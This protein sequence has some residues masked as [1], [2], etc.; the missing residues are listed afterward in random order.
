VNVPADI[1]RAHEQVV[2]G[3]RWFGW[4]HH[5]TIKRE[6][7]VDGVR[8]VLMHRATGGRKHTQQWIA[9]W[10]VQRYLTPRESE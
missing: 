2:V 5:W 6:R 7:T 10:R 8:E 4:G 1:E 9:A 3:S